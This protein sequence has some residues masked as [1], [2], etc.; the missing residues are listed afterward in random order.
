MSRDFLGIPSPAEISMEL[1]EGRAAW[2]AL[3]VDTCRIT[4]PGEGEPV[5][6]EATG[7]RTSP[8]PVV[9]Y[10]GPCLLQIRADV[11]SNVVEVTAGEREWAYQTSILSIPI[12]APSAS[13]LMPSQRATYPNGALGDPGEV[14]IDMTATMLTSAED[15]SLVGNVFHIKATL[16]KTRATA[17]R[18]RVTET[19]G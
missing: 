9:V 11:N 8:A 16:T 13:D 10:E 18:L 15:P 2:L 7:K 4:M 5:L 1:A 19:V 6:D 12:F 17:R 14:R 3:A